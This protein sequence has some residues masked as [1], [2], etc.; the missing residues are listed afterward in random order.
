MPKTHKPRAGSMQ[1][2]PRSRSKTSYA[3]IHSWAKKEKVLAFAGYKA[4]MT[5]ILENNPKAKVAKTVSIPVTVIECP[6]LKPLS[7]R[8]YKNTPYGA[9]I[10]SEVQAKNLNK[11]L[12]KKIRLP[13]A[14]K[15]KSIPE[16]YDYFRLAVYTQPKLTNIGKKRPDIFEIA[17]Q[18]NIEEAKKLLDSEIK[19]NSVFKS[20]QF[21]DVHAITKGKGFQGPVKRFGVQLKSHKSEK[22]RR[23]AGN[24]G[25]FTPRKVN[26]NVPQHGQ[27]GYFKRTEH[28]KLVYLVDSDPKKINQKGGMK[29]YGVLKNDYL[30]IKG[31]IA[32]P[33]KR[34]IILSEPIRNKKEKPAPEI[35]Y[36]SQESKQ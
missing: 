16:S 8:F 27:M 13:K 21:V 14:H 24:L 28:N 22:K 34:L 5:H 9:K 19:L 20:G 29:G 18:N 17:V 33:R 15:E 11:E 4:G 12:S 32:G 7:L 31:S 2:W 35:L 23:S 30:L 1:F 6:P 36:I 3:N 10:I 26:W 25:A